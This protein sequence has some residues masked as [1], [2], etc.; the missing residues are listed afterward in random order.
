VTV[1]HQLLFRL[2]NRGWQSGGDCTRRYAGATIFNGFH[3]CRK[4]AFK[5]LSVKCGLM[6][7][8][9]FDERSKWRGCAPVIERL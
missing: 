4:R 6:L 1:V 7:G 5:P 9:A 2:D 3:T 8:F